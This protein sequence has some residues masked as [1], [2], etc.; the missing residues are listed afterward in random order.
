[1]A[2]LSLDRERVKSDVSAI[3]RGGSCGGGYARE[4][5]HGLWPRTGFHAYNN[6]Y[7]APSA[8][9]GGGGGGA[10]GSV[11]ASAPGWR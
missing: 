6:R 3:K 2:V 1:M 7:V 4:N 8:A 10:D 11:T 5:V 9:E